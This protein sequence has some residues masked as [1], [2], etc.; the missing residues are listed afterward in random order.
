MLR[1]VFLALALLPQR[2]WAARDLTPPAPEFPGAE[3]WINAKPLTL[4]RLRHRRAVVVAFI[5]TSNINSIRSFSALKAWWNQYSLEGLM[6]IG[7]HTPDYS[8]QKNPAIVRQAL[9]RFSIDFP[10]VLDDERRIWTAYSNEGWP[11]FYLLDHTGLIVFDRLGEGGYEDFETEIRKVVAAVPGY[12]EPK[13]PPAAQDPPSSEC[14]EMTHSIEAGTRRGKA[15]SLDKGEARESSYLVASRD[16][17]LAMGGRWT[18][19]ADAL[20]LAQKNSNRSAYLRLIYRGAQAFGLLAPSGKA[21]ARV[22]VRQ[23]D[24]W[25]HPGNAGQDVAFDEEGISYVTVKEGRLYELAKN[26]TDAVH[27]LHLIP[28]TPGTAV[29]AFEFSDR[30]GRFKLP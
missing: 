16:G 26:A 4:E 12:D 21:P 8:F 28:E 3:V 24:L 14:G 30:C 29:Y 17:E 23:D 22:L 25:L 15:L 5:N 10:V 9:K 19:E 2:A 1:S 18:A 27:E 7:V 11:A 6:V 13:A 20:R